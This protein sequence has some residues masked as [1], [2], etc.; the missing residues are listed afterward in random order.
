MTIALIDADILVYEAAYRAQESFEWE[1]GEFTEH[2]SLEGATA[3]FQGRIADI[4]EKTGAEEKILA[5]SST[6]RDANFRRRVWSK[7]KE[8]RS[9]ASAKRPLLFKALRQWIRDEYGAKEKIGIEADDTIGILA[10]YDSITMPPIEDRIICS[11]D[12]DLL[13]IPGKHFNWR[14]PE[15][16]L[17][18]VDEEVAYGYF[19]CQSLIGDS[20]DGYPGCKGI[21]PVAAMRILGDLHPRH[22]WWAVVQAFCARGFD[23]KFALS[24]ARCARILRAKDWDFAAEQALLWIPERDTWDDA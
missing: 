1:P 3:D 8:D 23:E 16:G 13:T 20:T 21:G 10:T 4:M 19:M 7:Y 15:D 11:I 9:K 18:D 17:F 12:K 22:M 14:K 5:L 24:Q 6:D 2:A